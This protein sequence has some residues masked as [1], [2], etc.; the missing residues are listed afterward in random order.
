MV[1]KKHLA[2]AVQRGLDGGYL[3]KDVRTVAIILDHGLDAA[4]LA[5]NPVQAAD[6]I[7][8]FFWISVFM[9]AGTFL[10][11]FFFSGS[12]QC[13]FL[14]LSDSFIVGQTALFWTEAS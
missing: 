10:Q 2:E 13:K 11:R 8:F 6:Q 3:N 5:F 9:T 1:G 4:D 12:I 7:L 14:L